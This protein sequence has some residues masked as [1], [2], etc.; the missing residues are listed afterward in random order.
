MTT[1]RLGQAI[2]QVCGKMLRND[3]ELNDGQLLESFVVG[4]ETAALEALVGRHGPMVWGVCRR[5][6]ANHHDAEDAAT[7]SSSWCAGVLDQAACYGRQLA[8]QRR[9][10]LVALK[11]RATTAK[12]PPREKQ[13]SAQAEPAAKCPIEPERCLRSA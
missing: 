9:R 5:V 12:Q 7:L 8:L 3:A 11:A 1:S 13:L 10:H 2:H 6:L 4:R